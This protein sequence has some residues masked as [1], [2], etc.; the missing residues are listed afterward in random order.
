MCRVFGFAPSTYYAWECKQE[1]E[2]AI[3]DAELL[4]AIRRI[5]ATFR[6]RYGAPEFEALTAS[7][8]RGSQISWVWR[9]GQSL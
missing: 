2:H 4:T 3:W 7:D 6:G 8:R 5:F 9:V 1:S